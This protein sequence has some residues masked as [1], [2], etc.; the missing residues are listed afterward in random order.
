M[1]KEYQVVYSND[2]MDIEVGIR[3]PIS[4]RK[5]GVAGKALRTAFPWGQLFG[6]IDRKTPALAGA[7]V[8]DTSCDSQSWNAGN[9]TSCKINRLNNLMGNLLMRWFCVLA[10]NYARLSPPTAKHLEAHLYTNVYR[11]FSKVFLL[12][13]ESCRIIVSCKTLSSFSSCRLIVLIEQNKKTATIDRRR[14]ESVP[15]RNPSPG[16]HHWPQIPCTA[17]KHQRLMD[18]DMV[19]RT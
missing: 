7:T 15:P 12:R 1:F 6:T 2:Y 4:S 14:W 9:G 16:H 3:W 19:W 13:E 8:F 17:C 11:C 18:E 10:K 5:S